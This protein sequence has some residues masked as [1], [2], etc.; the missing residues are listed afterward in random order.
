M[1]LLEAWRAFEGGYGDAATQ[2]V[3]NEKMPK[4]VKKRRL[5][6]DESGAE[7]GWEEY[8]DYEFPDQQKGKANLA[9][10]QKARAWKKQKMAATGAG[11]ES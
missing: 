6:T 1:L 4:R 9:L 11:Q 8:Y 10:L 2:A 3:V 5:L 7:A